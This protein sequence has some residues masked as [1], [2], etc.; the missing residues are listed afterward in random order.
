MIVDVKIKKVIHTDAKN[1]FQIMEVEPISD[2][3]WEE[4]EANQDF[5]IRKK[6][7]VKGVMPTPKAG[8]KYTITGR[9]TI[10]NELYIS[11]TG[12]KLKEFELVEELEK[13]IK[14]NVKGVGKSM[15]K[16]LVDAYGINTREIITAE[17]G[18]D[19]IRE[20]LYAPNVKMT[21]KRIENVE[22]IYTALLHH[23]NSLLIMEFLQING[24][25]V[26]L[27][28]DIIAEYGSENLQQMNENPYFF[29]RAVNFELLDKIAYLKGLKKDDIRR[30]KAGIQYFIELETRGKKNVFSYLENMYE[31]IESIINLNSP[32]EY[33][34]VSKERANEALNELL[35]EK[36][37]VL[38]NDKFLYKSYL[39]NKEVEVV[40]NVKRLTKPTRIDEDAVEAL[41]LLFEA[42]KG[43]K[44][45]EEQREA[46]KMTMRNDL[47]IIT[48]L[49]GAGKTLVISAIIYVYKAM[50]PDNTIAPIA[51]TGKASKR[52]SEV[53]R[54]PATTIHRAL[55]IQAG[56]EDRAQLLEQ[57]FIIVDEVS[58]LD[59]YLCGTLLA[60]VKTGAKVLFVGDV[61]QLPSV[62]V[63]LVLR[64]LINSGKVPVTRLTKFFRQSTNSNIV[65]NAH[66]IA[67]REYK[68]DF[69]NDVILWETSPEALHTRTVKWYM[70]LLQEGYSRD[71]IAILSPQRDGVGGTVEINKIIQATFNKDKKE[72]AINK[73]G[74][75]IR[76]DDIVIHTENN[77]E[78]EVYNG[79]VGRVVNVSGS[80]KNISIEVK[81]P[82]R[83]EVVVYTEKEAKQ[84]EL[85]YALTIHKSQGSEYRAVINICSKRHSYMLDRNL[86]YTAWTRAKEKLLILGDEKTI[87]ECVRKSKS[88]DRNSNLVDRLNDKVFYKNEEVKEITKEIT[89]EMTRE[90]IIAFNEI[91]EIF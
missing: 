30:V 18:R 84:L 45:S 65:V 51:P 87:N 74:D 41:I 12:A 27:V 35:F 46:V 43:L 79:E 39:Y 63:G 1:N 91:Q 54:T 72:V 7:K 40:R 55:K 88:F 61:E 64:D 90:E 78:L 56:M 11:L 66:T 67:N 4:G 13:F 83:E 50:Y 32:F 59:I 48:G 36:Q 25:P 24:L 80:G 8:D 77:S 85:A 47:S 2:V 73:A 76:I 14:N 23:K 69:S 33:Q 16:K 75:K 20:A 38:S 37:V 28:N 81:Y 29:I 21:K 15:A 42:E 70:K 71:E 26:S 49:P 10:N 19:K 58:M 9:L 5:A 60:N 31:E 89:K 57:D 34:A 82:D 62:G 6:M 3:I 44:L 53:S 68:F 17:D 22:A 86:I 52:M